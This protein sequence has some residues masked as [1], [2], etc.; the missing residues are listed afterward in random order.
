MIYI[1][2]PVHDERHTIGPLLW[3]IRQLLLARGRDFH[4]VVLDDA[5]TDG[6]GKGL[7]A[8][9]RVLP[10]TLL[11]NEARQ[12]YAASLER[13]V[14]EVV[15]RSGY[16]RRDALV[17]LQADLTDAPEAI[18]EMIR[19]FEGGVDLLLAVPRR[20]GE[21]PAG[22]EEGEEVGDAETAE[23]GR[24]APPPRA[25]RLAR[26]GARL[27]ARG[28]PRPP[29]VAD[30]Y[31]SFRLYRLFTLARALR[32]LPSRDAPL[33]TQEGWAAN[34]ELLLAAWPHVRRMEEV[35]WPEDCGR[36]YRGSRFRTV[37][38]L[39]SLRLASRDPR[40]AGL[41]QRVREGSAG[42]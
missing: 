20:E 2:I 41:G 11:R 1:G 29:G 16:P 38:E 28:L 33:L 7:A 14:R 36:R 8:Y 17:T 32:D 18:P 23:A 30:P 24:T 27:V 39:R 19:R 40:V 10:M 31:G 42:G 6:T 25:M 37:A 4:V 3:R 26:L 15:G 9:G 22:E 35:A 21:E 12:G 13:L 5:S 34:A